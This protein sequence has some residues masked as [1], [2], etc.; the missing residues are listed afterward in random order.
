MKNKFRWVIA[1]LLFAA[2]MINFI[3]R[4]ALSIVAPVMT[5]ELH[6]EPAMLGVLFS[7]FFASYTVFGLFGGYVI[8]RFSPKWF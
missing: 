7:A 3:D 4:S 6:I 8:D 2:A 1:A 5:K